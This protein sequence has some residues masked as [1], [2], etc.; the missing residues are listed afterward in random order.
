MAYLKWQQLRDIF[1]ATAG[2]IV[3]IVGIL[4]LSG[5]SYSTPPDIACGEDCYS[6]IQVNSTYWEICAEH[7]DRED[8]IYKKRTRSRRIWVNLNMID[9]FI[10]T[11]PE[12]KT[13]LLVPTIKKYS[14]IN[15]DEFGYLRPIK[16]GDC[17][18]KRK[19]KY[20]P[21]GSRFVIHGQK[22]ASQDV[23]W[24]MN[25]ENVLMKDI[26]LDPLWEGI[27][28][29]LPTSNEYGEIKYGVDFDDVP[30]GDNKRQKT[31][32][33][34][35]RNVPYQGEMYRIE[36]APS[37]KEFT[38]PVFTKSDAL[39]SSQLDFEIIDYNL[40]SEVIRI[41]SK[42]GKVKTKIPYKIKYDNSTTEYNETSK[43]YD[44]KEMH[45]FVKKKD[46]DLSSD[47]NIYVI[48]L[49]E[50]KSIFDG[51]FH[52]GESSETHYYNYSLNG[53]ENHAY[54]H[55]SG[56][57][58]PLDPDVGNYF[59]EYTDAEYVKIA[60]DDGDKNQWV[61]PSG[62]WINIWYNFTIDEDIGD[63]TAI[64]VLWNGYDT[65]PEGDDFEFD[66]W[67]ASSLAW[68][69][70]NTTTTVGSADKDYGTTFTSSL[71]DYLD[72]ANNLHLGISGSKG[73]S[74]PYI[75]S[76][77]GS[78]YIYEHEAYP[79]AGVGAM[80][81]DET[82]ETLKYL[83][84]SEDV[85]RLRMTEELPEVSYTNSVKVYGIQHPSDVEVLSDFQGNFHTISEM[86]LPSSCI[87]IFGENCLDKINQTDELFWIADIDTVDPKT[88]GFSY[89][90]L[91]FDKPQNADTAKLRFSIKKTEFPIWVWMRYIKII[92]T[93]D[94][95]YGLLEKGE[96]PS[97][98]YFPSMFRIFIWN[99]T[100]WE[101]A[102]Q[103]GIGAVDWN[104]RLVFINLTNV[105]GD[106]VKFRL[107]QISGF[108]PIDSVKI[109]YTKDK[110]MKIEQLNLISAID[111]K[112]ND[113]KEKLM[114]RDQERIN[115]S[116]GDYVDLVFD[117]GTLESD[118]Y[119][120][121]ISGYYIPIMGHGEGDGFTEEEKELIE[122]LGTNNTFYAEYWI[123]LYQN[124]TDKLGGHTIYEDFVEA[125]ITFGVEPEGDTCDYTS[126]TWEIDC[127]ENCIIDTETNIGAN[128]VYFSGAGTVLVDEDIYYRRSYVGSGCI[129]V[130]DSG[131]KMVSG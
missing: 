3:L 100:D 8:I 10:P 51:E 38:K 15:H 121:S 60:E 65:L 77:N 48:T 92:G 68:I 67:N 20:N 6:Q 98:Y 128:D 89:I 49:S 72:S 83:D 107:M 52:L 85:L 108:Y 37:L 87:D 104:D 73:E 39:I 119:I 19:T 82:Y 106:K 16:D 42:I 130:I 88:E 22:D 124:S 79:W 81:P 25:L 58:T 109:D 29:F 112:N 14:T 2:L 76:W 66:I 31:L 99:G 102:D 105:E 44:E 43:K 74:C 111:N 27:S 33:M 40:T 86:E 94:Y 50:N 9:E 55:G 26:E 114:D 95:V 30:I 64:K 46:I 23:K 116:K 59:R 78:E 126:G 117:K 63:I 41:T 61:P 97:E 127:S 70:I 7:S 57:D 28:T 101:L 53:T 96:I 131:N 21:K 18:I 17:F 120:M 12:V 91:E 103:F 80:A 47:E 118:S 93:I 129:V 115:M 62:N 5:M 125:V 123:S 122:K 13:E 54:I 4:N 24:G 84:T 90:D 110:E 69:I 71:S 35:I 36:K 45:Y 1:G 32:Y 113:V 75:Y 34:G 56:S 11:N